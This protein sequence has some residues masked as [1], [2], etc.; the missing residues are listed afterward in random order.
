M[1]YYSVGWYK[2]TSSYYWWSNWQSTNVTA[3]LTNFKLNVSAGYT[4]VF[5]VYAVTVHGAGSSTSVRKSIP[6][7]GETVSYAH[8]DVIGRY[9]LQVR[10][11]WNYWGGD[12]VRKDPCILIN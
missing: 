10:V 4:Y 7:L 11:H 5:Y 1:Q 6:P 2:S 9:G 3:P 12:A 8:A